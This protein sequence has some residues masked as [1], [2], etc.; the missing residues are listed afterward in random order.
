MNSIIVMD[1]SCQ[2]ITRY[3]MIGAITICD[4]ILSC[5]DKFKQ[6]FNIRFLIKNRF[7]HTITT[8]FIIIP[9]KENNRNL[10]QSC[11]YSLATVDNN[12]TVS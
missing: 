1:A 8:Y 9:Q 2:I 4:R 7:I 10:Y 3:Q 6:N 11:G 5:S 12:D